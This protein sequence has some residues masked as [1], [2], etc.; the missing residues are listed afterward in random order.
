MKSN[1]LLPYLLLCL[2]ACSKDTSHMYLKEDYPIEVGNWWIY[3]KES[4]VTGIDT[5]K[6]VVN[7]KTITGKTTIFKCT[8]FNIGYNQNT[9]VDSSYFK[10]SDTL[11]EYS[12]YD[13]ENYSIADFKIK[14]P[15]NEYEKWYGI[16][17]K[18]S[19]N[20]SP[21]IDSIKG[22]KRTYKEVFS[23]NREYN[24]SN[25]LTLNNTIYLSKGYG[26]AIH[27]IRVIK[28]GNTERR[29]GLY[30]INQDLK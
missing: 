22:Y 7:S 21:V 30:L 19:Y 3:Y 14:I 15:F 9:L 5:F 28:N 1:K 18:D 6:L 20:A 13:P 8:V 2:F 23:L 4:M 29:E 11:I 24:D 25:G 26:M 16:N 17:T 10:V 27:F 12:S